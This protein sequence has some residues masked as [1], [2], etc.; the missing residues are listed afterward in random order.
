ML[1]HYEKII[2]RKYIVN[3]MILTFKID[4]GTKSLESWPLSAFQ[5]TSKPSPPPETK[6]A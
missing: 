4:L 5:I 1:D 2:E 3:K 6:M